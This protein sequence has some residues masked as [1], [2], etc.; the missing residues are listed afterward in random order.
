MN[1]EKTTSK[2]AALGRSLEDFK[3]LTLA[4]KE[5]LK[6]ASEGCECV[7][8]EGL[9]ENRL[10]ENSVRASLVRF[11]L[12]SGDEEAPVHEKGIEI[13]GAHIVGKL[14]LDGCRNMM[15]LV[16]VDCILEEPIRAIDSSIQIFV[17]INSHIEGYDENGISIYADRIHVEGDIQVADECRV[18][19]SVYIG[20]ASVGGV[21]S[22]KGTSIAFKKCSNNT[23]LFADAFSTKSDVFLSDG[24]KARGEVRFIGAEIAG[25]FVCTRGVFQPASSSESFSASSK[26][27]SLSLSHARIG[28]ALMLDLTS[29]G[30]NRAAKIFGGLNLQGAT[31]NSLMDSNEI[32]A[33]T[34]DPDGPAGYI[35]L[36][37][38]TYENLLDK[39]PTDAASR[40]V[41]LR[42]QPEV[43]LKKNFRIQPYQQLARV[44]KKMGHENDALE[45]AILKEKMRS[46][47]GSMPKFSRTWHFVL[48]FLVSYGYRPW[49]VAYF[50]LALWIV[51]AVLFEAGWKAGDIVPSQPIIA[52]REEYRKCREIT[53]PSNREFLSITER[54]ELH[55]V[56][57]NC[58]KGASIERVTSDDSP[59]LEQDIIP[60][61]LREYPGFY[62]V[63]YS[64]DVLLPIMDFDQEQYWRPSALTDFGQSL[65]V[66][67]WSFKAI[68]W[69]LTAVGA[70]ALS[71]FVRND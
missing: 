48:G 16:L 22:F 63:M 46:N 28:E 69:F 60:N 35:V 15:G 41:W 43:H 24:F 49:R 40:E 11:L 55:D 36:D 68:G 44:L 6:C 38:F 37:G 5:L 57:V 19:G 13:R 31:V 42:K 26:D 45:I 12:L 71:G 33:S 14:D 1:S 8:S 25:S 47:S 58:L 18:S 54:I 70:A 2:R 4:E 53:H 27:D 21:V 62:S 56:F 66:V 17:L 39:A 34:D 30:P 64:L 59:Q 3:S 51:G 61:D 67:Q 50:G 7:I 10:Q 9:P 23:A 29:S 32:F 20:G 65:R 52:L